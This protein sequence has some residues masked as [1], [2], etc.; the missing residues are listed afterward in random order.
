MKF[1][2]FASIAVLLGLCLS[3]T[4]QEKGASALLS[5]PS[6]THSAPPAEKQ[7][8]AKLFSS[9]VAPLGTVGKDGRYQI[10]VVKVRG[11]DTPNIA[12]FLIYDAA[13]DE[14]IGTQT[15]AAPGLGVALVN[16]GSSVA[17][18]YLF[19]SKL[20]PSTDSTSTTV[21]NNSGSTASGGNS[22][23]RSGATSH[24]GSSSTSTAAGGN[25]NA[26]GGGSFIPPGH[27]DN[28]GHG[29]HHHG[30]N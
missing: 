24:S 2:M 21:S 23:A 12:G 6:T 28:P 19:G 27:I 20:R 18:S 14:I 22:N 25:S 16:G 7:Q 8:H 26:N 13:T 9:Y 3:A 29:G 10:V 5:K 17:G 11:L 1:N 4:A 15:G 30:N